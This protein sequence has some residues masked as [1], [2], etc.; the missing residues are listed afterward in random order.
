MRVVINKSHNLLLSLHCV[1]FSL[2]WLAIQAWF[3]GSASVL[4]SASSS[5]HK[6]CLDLMAVVT[7]GFEVDRLQFHSI[8]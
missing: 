3:M 8:S 7:E 2:K 4:S 1:R 5:I 6:H